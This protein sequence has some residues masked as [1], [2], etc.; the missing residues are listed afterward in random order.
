M[1]RLGEPG[2]LFLP[3]ATHHEFIS[4]SYE[5]VS[6]RDICVQPLV[7]LNG[8]GDNEIFKVGYYERRKAWFCVSVVM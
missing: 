3:F 4:T 8:G 1:Q 2:E 7:R 6:R 5:V